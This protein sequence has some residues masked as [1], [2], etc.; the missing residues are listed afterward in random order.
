MYTFLVLCGKVQVVLQFT[1]YIFIFP[2]NYSDFNIWRNLKFLVNNLRKV[3]ADY[4][5]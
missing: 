3:M 1:R 4:I 5:S 2:F